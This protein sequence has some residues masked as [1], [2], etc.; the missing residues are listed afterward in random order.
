MKYIKIINL[1]KYQ[2]GATNK[3]WIKWWKRCLIDPNF[4]QLSDGERWLFVGLVILAVDLNNRIPEDA[5]WVAQRVLYRGGQRGAQRACREYH[6]GLKKM[7]FLRLISL[8]DTPIREEKIRKEKSD[9]NIFKD[10][11][12]SKRNEVREFLQ[13]KGVLKKI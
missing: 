1:E 8:C 7:K 12:A 9:L 6:R 5:Q 13:K 4:L 3:P 2:Q 10:D 11:T